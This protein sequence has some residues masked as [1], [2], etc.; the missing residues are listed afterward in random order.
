VTVCLVDTSVLC[1]VLRVPGKCQR[2]GIEDALRVRIEAGESLL[3][4]IVAVVEL[5][6]MIGQLADGTARRRTAERFVEFLRSAMDGTPGESERNPFTL[7]RILGDEQVLRRMLD[8]FVEQATSGLG[9]GDLAIRHEFE[10]LRGQHRRRRVY[11]WTFDDR[12]LGGLD[13]GPR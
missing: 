5:G 13:T 11:V 1:E 7:T 4:P 12:H 3:I 2:G 9:V 10:L 8:D 6:N